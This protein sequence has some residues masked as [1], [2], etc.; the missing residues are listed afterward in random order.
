MKCIDSAL[1]TSKVRQLV[2]KVVVI[3]GGKISISRN[4][5]TDSVEGQLRPTFVNMTG[6]APSAVA[7]L[8][9]DPDDTPLNERRSMVT[10]SN[11]TLM[12]TIVLQKRIAPSGSSSEAYIP[13]HFILRVV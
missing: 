2:L 6:L 10:K 8:L 5:I 12:L 4:Q 9:S 13:Y 3:P 1:Q 7:D 11:T